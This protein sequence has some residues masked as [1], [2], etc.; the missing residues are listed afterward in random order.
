[1]EWKRELVV[2]AVATQKELL[3]VPVAACV[4]SPQPFG[5]SRNAKYVFGHDRDGR[6]VLAPNAPRSHEIRGHVRLPHR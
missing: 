4:P 2:E 3:G 6:L 5:L 1:V